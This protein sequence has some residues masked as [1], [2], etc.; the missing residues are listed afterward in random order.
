[1]IEAAPAHR[2][3]AAMPDPTRAPPSDPSSWLAP[4]D[5]FLRTW[6]DLP[7]LALVDESC[8]DE[9]RLHALAGR[10][11]QAAVPAAE[12]AALSTP[13]L[14]PTTQTYLAIR[15]A[16]CAAGTLE[17]YY[18]ALASRR[19][20]RD[21]AGVRRTH[22]RG[23]RRRICSTGDGDPFE[24]RAAQLLYPPAA[25]R[26]A[27]WPRPQ[28]RPRNSRQP[29]VRSPRSTSCDSPTGGAADD[30]FAGLPVLGDANAHRVRQRRR[31]ASPSS[32]T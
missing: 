1:M 32:S 31:S 26:P 15:D 23:D 11:A 3:M 28:R 5:A 6:L 18:L 24:Q 21:P 25:H 19:P 30:D 16:L 29:S 7:E 2:I 12:L 14:A 13:T 4:S 20:D 8:A 27:R 10:A 9:R 17:A 22:R